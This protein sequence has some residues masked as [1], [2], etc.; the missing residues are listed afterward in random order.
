VRNKTKRLGA[1]G[2]TALVA[3]VVI[4]SSG[5]AQA[6]T[7]TTVGGSTTTTTL[8][9]QKS[10]HGS[11]NNNNNC[12]SA[13]NPPIQ[14]GG[15][16]NIGV[17]LSTDA[18]PQ[19]HEGDPIKLTNSKVSISIPASL[20]Q[21]GV[22]AGI[23]TDGQKIPSQLALVVAGSNTTQATHK[24]VVNSTVTVHV[25][26]GQ[27]QPLTS[28]L[29]LADTTWTPLSK[30]QGVSFTEKSMVI[31][32]TID[33]TSSLGI[34]LIATFTCKPAGTADFM[35]IGG[36]SV[37]VTTT[38]VTTTTIATT[39]VAPTVA[40]Q[41]TNTNTLPRTGSET[42]WLLALAVVLL[43]VGLFALKASG[44]RPTRSRP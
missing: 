24:Y 2:A 37:P 20:L 16:D 39:T 17:T 9:P 7:T 29:N 13:L 28:T 34:V 40:P 8:P 35:A 3:L 4:G 44:R 32:S 18:F 41:A 11:T 15:P 33:L 10:V 38:T 43:S 36:I 31:T 6:A 5:I 23:I 21:V 25:I 22:G 19:P 26:A 42:G 27:A 14:P 12:Q 1:L 30:F